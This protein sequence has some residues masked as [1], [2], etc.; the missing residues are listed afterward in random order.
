MAQ[1][2]IMGYGTVGAGVFKTLAMNS[3]AIARRVGEEICVKSVLDL[4][5]C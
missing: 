3:E 5:V 4:R 1:I 2:A